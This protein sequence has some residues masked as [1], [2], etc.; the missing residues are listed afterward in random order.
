MHYNLKNINF[1]KRSINWVHEK[2]NEKQFLI[3][4]SILVGVSAGLAAVT[5]KLFVFFIKL[6]IVLKQ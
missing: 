1:I 2:T 6:S 3:F 4:A 5:L